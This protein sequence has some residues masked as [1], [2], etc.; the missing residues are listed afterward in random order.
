MWWS[1]QQPSRLLKLLLRAVYLAPFEACV[2]AGALTLMS[3]FNDLNGIPASANEL[4]LRRILKEEWGFS[5]FV[6][7]DWGS[8]S[9]L[10]QHGFCEDGRQVALEALRAG[11]DMEMAARNYLEHVA[12]LIE[13][14]LLSVELVDDAVRRILYVKHALGLFEEPY[15]ERPRTSV[16][17][18]DPHLEVAREAAQQSIVLLKNEGELLPLAK[19]VRR[20]AVV[21][22]LADDAKNQLGCWAYDGSS[23]TA[24]T[25][26][27]ALRER[28]GSTTDVQYARGLESS[29]STDESEIDAAVEVAR[30]ADVAVVVLGEDAN[31]SGECRSRAFL[32]L[33]GAQQ[34]L[35]ERLAETKTPLV[36]ILMAGRPLVINAPAALAQ[37]VLYAWHPGTMAGPGLVDVLLG[38]VAPSGKLPVSFPR[39]VGQIPVYYGIK[40][41]GRPPKTEFRGIPEG[42]PL[43]PVDFDSSYLDVEVSPQF[44]FGFGLSY[45][46]FACSEVRVSPERASVG[47]S[48]TVTA[49]VANIGKRAAAEVVQLYVRDLVGSVTRPV[50]ELKGFQRV[51]L[52]PGE[53]R[54]VRFTLTPDELAFPGRDMRK[55]VEP[56]RFQIFVGGDSRAPLGGEFELT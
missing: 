14:G 16:I 52:E 39:T 22:P 34:K 46:T 41:T 19:G 55:V 10:V 42:T 4:T 28:M 54:E 18:G 9:E 8:T 5:G 43:D 15:V 1:E 53:A 36:L 7:S 26:V 24:V 50:R 47:A 3:G 49:R 32:D 13:Q 56:G 37:A 31:I 35:L 2:K 12:G 38:D 29:R 17:L 23:E 6:V 11:L 30:E 45:T 40:S 25:L 27:A 48:V 20:V 44:P 33:P 21:G 51:W